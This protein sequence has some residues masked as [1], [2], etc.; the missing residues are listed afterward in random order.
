MPTPEFETQ[1]GVHAANWQSSTHPCRLCP[2]STRLAPRPFSVHQCFRARD[3]DPEEVP[4]LLPNPPTG[5][6]HFLEDAFDGVDATS[7]RQLVEAFEC[8]EKLQQVTAA[9]ITSLVV[10]LQ[11]PHNP[12]G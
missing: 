8:G 10:C 7:A 6:A 12:L 2:T 11:L 3:Y 5:L 9:P 1:T 4:L